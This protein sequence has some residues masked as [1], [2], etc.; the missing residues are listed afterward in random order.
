M[1]KYIFKKIFY[2]KIMGGS[3][4]KARSP[5]SRIWGSLHESSA[6]ASASPLNPSTAS[7]ELVYRLLT[8]NIFCLFV[9]IGSLYFCG[10][11]ASIIIVG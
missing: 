10:I 8:K 9:S 6:K 4:A 1:Y 3:L 2:Q 11:R 7:Y 5:N